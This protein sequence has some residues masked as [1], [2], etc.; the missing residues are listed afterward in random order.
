MSNRSGKL[1]VFMAN[2]CWLLSCLPG[3]VVF[4][5]STRRVRFVQWRVLACILKCNVKTKIGKRY[6]FDQIHMPD[7]YKIIP[8]SEYDDYATPISEIKAGQPSVLTRDPVQILQPTS[9]STRAT[10]LIPY[11]RSLRAQ[12]KAA[13]DPWI[14]T[15]FLAHP[16][17][18]LGRHYWSISPSTS[19]PVDST[20]KVRV[21]FADDAEYLGFVQRLLARAL[22]VVP[23]EI[24]RVTDPAA[25]EYLTLLFLCRERNLR[26][27]SVWHPSFLTVLLKALPVHYDSIIHDIDSGTLTREL[28]LPPQLRDAFKSRLS[29]APRRAGEL[30]PIDLMTPDWPQRLWPALRLISCWTDGISEPWV[31]ELARGFPRAIIQG[32]GLTATEGIVTFPLGKNGQKVLA[33]R[34][35]YY[36]FA[37]VDTDVLRNAWE[38]ETGREYGVILTTGGGFYR[39]RLHDVVRVTGFHNQAPCLEFLGRDNLVSDLVGEK[40]NAR[41]VEACLRAVERDWGRRFSFAMLAPQVE[42]AEAVYVLYAQIDGRNDGASGGGGLNAAG[43]YQH[44][45]AKMESDLCRNYH[46]HHAR[47]LG[48]LQPVRI[49]RIDRDAELSY[50]RH[51]QGKGMKAG[52]IKFQALSSDRSWGGVFSGEYVT[53]D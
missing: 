44:V 6:H 39:Y 17:L 12:F 22:F 31:S 1:R 36:E 37:E 10:K 23:P 48:Q 21:G 24:A 35:H 41:H 26:L 49:F 47:Q 5:W 33:V 2:L 11:T 43:D 15:L 7:D 34:S 9:G 40:L 19:P 27:I 52:E 3:W 30:R 51:L 53:L 14:A 20:S 46:Y 45:A 4:L 28:N 29:P 38:L 32:K 50:R 16:S 13:I 8:L 18:L 25:F 42:G